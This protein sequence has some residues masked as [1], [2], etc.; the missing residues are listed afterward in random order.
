MKTAAQEIERIKALTKVQEIIDALT[1]LK[2]IFK[3]LSNQEKIDFLQ[4]KCKSK[5]SIEPTTLYSH[6]MVI[7]SVDIVASY[8]KLV[9]EAL[10]AEDIDAETKLLLLKQQFDDCFTTMLKF[11]TTNI[12]HFSP[13]ADGLVPL[14]AILRSTQSIPQINKFELLKTQ[15]TQHGEDLFTIRRESIL[16]ALKI[17]LPHLKKPADLKIIFPT[18]PPEKLKEKIKG[19]TGFKPFVEA[20]LIELGLLDLTKKTPAKLYAETLESNI[21]SDANYYLACLILAGKAKGEDLFSVSSD[22]VNFFTP[23]EH[24]GSITIKL[25]PEKYALFLLKRVP[26]NSTVH[27]E[28]TK[29]IESLSTSWSAAL[30]KQ[31]TSYV[32][33]LSSITNKLRY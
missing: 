24:I 4:T 14:I 2:E 22:A 17:S 10:E 32:P 5:W 33:Y 7:Q 29:K 12:M 26:T 3:T 18:T 30:F 19:I 23:D 6:F 27:E 25:T 28:A 13:I 8:F 20:R 1:E 31:A 21:H 11:R 15:I 16:D 9:T